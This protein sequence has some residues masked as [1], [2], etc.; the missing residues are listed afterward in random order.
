MPHP[1]GTATMLP[2]RKREILLPGPSAKNTSFM[3]NVVYFYIEEGGG[4]FFRN[5]GKFPPHPRRQYSSYSAMCEPQPS[6]VSVNIKIFADTVT[7]TA[8]LKYNYT[9]IVASHTSMCF[10]RMVTMC[11]KQQKGLA[12]NMCVL[13][14]PLRPPRTHRGL[15]RVAS[16]RAAAGPKLSA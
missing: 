10:Q 5:V 13:R 4:T 2:P 3:L 11:A 9:Y 12:W 7:K 8:I 14:R 16:L 1:N 15:Q 6:E